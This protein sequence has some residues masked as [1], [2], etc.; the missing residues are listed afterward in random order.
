[1]PKHTAQGSEP[2]RRAL[3]EEFPADESLPREPAG[4]S[5]GSD[6]ERGHE[7]QKMEEAK[8]RQ[9]RSRSDRPGS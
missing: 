5:E 8:V 4:V 3:N 7:R 2:Q 1:M 6:E 9:S